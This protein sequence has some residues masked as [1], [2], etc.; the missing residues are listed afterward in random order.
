MYVVKLQ[1][2]INVCGVYGHF[3]FMCRLSAKKYQKSNFS[4]DAVILRNCH[5]FD[6]LGKDVVKL[7]WDSASCFNNIRGWQK[8]KDVESHKMKL[9][10]LYQE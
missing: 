4:H 7:S 5:H 3:M 1:G 9:L 6:I 10:I 2:F 8:Q